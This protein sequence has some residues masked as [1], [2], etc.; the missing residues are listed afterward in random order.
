MQ[1]FAWALKLHW[2]AANESRPRNAGAWRQR[3][4]EELAR[5]QEYRNIAKTL[6]AGIS[7][8][9]Q[10]NPNTSIKPADGAQ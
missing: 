1:A 8:T 6:Q 4:R 10:Q 9:Q 7:P 5:A 2:L 3:V